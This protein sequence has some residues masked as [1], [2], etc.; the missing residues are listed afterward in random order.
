L[1][2]AQRSALPAVI[3]R[4]SL[5]VALVG[6]AC[7]SAASVAPTPSASAVPSIGV[8]ASASTLA[9]PVAP[10]A[11][12]TPVDL[13]SFKG[14]GSKR[15]QAVYLSGDY[16]LADSVSARAGCHWSLALTPD[17]GTLDEFSTDAPG[18]H[19]VSSDLLG[20]HAQLYRFE[21][22]SRKC[23]AWTVSITAK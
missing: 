17:Y 16:R 20:V 18:S 7:T 14:T 2:R 12:P 8:T 11:N 21:V 3:V 10:S 9:S 4:L 13:L 22:T 1:D 23:G 6:G 19:R 15:S 5:S